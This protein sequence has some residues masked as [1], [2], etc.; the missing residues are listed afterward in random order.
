MASFPTGYGRAP[1]LLYSSI[2][3]SHLGRTNND[4]F[5][6][7]QQLSTGLQILK[8]SDDVVRAATVSTLDGRIERSD[9]LLRNF[10]YARSAL[11]TADQS[12]GDA[13]DLMNEAL[14]IALTQ[15]Q[16][17]STAEERKG[18]AIIVDSLVDS[19][20]RIASRES[21]VG[22]VF[23]G[24]QP[25][26]APVTDL[27]GAFRFEGGRGGLVTDLGRGLRIPVTLGAN[28][29]IG[30]LSNRVAGTVDLNPSI[31]T[32][33]RIAQLNGARDLGVS[34]GVVQAS[35]NGDTPFQIDLSGAD[36]IGDVVDALSSAIAKY[37]SDSGNTVL[38]TGGVSIADGSFTIDIVAGGSLEF[39]DLNGG[40]TG[41][42]LGL[43]FET[44]APFDELT[45]TAGAE[46]DPRLTWTSS[47][48]G[49]RGLAG[50]LGSIFVQNN[51]KGTE[52]DLSGATTLADIRSLIERGGTEVRVEINDA[53]TGINIVTQVAGTADRALSIHEIDDGLGN[54]AELLGIRSFAPGTLISDFNEGRGVQVVS[55]RTDL[56]GVL[57]P[58]LNTDFSIVLGDGFEIDIDLSES[59]LTT[60]SSVLGVINAQAG[61]QLTAAGRPLTD[62]EASLSPGLNGIVLTQAA[63]GGPLDVVS[64]NNSPAAEQLGLQSLTDLAGGLVFLGEDRAQVRVDNAF[65]ALMD[66]A[67][68]LR[69]NDRSGIQFASDRLEDM[70]DRLTEQRALVGGYAGQVDD[71]TVREED[72]NVLD[73]ATR[74]QLR[75]VDYAAAASRFAQLQ[76][77]LQATLY[78]TAQGQS[79]SLLDFLG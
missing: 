47:I 25:G 77:Q 35:F 38:D 65:T 24:T 40:S 9:Q 59:D 53:G 56:N 7:S 36:T 32:N 1:Q 12:L 74:S 61:A 60:V 28:N 44:P 19:L 33:T 21:V 5:R 73:V 3:L 13:F 23:G 20:Y 15:I 30:A 69:N 34:L 79:L 45:T 48:A 64:R 46:L 26:Q 58:E 2:N 10:E 66:L 42:D 55:G 4:L 41:A 76:T 39:S 22:Y 63:L 8:P 29:A 43:V 54:T 67:E 57:D 31:E 68:A 50:P 27:Q 49:L 51:G 17:T 75:D 52:I 70:V 14:G 37:E 16:S 11:D 18:Q 71:E 62:F 78:V 72:R 6:V